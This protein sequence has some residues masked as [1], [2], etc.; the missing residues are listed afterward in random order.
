MASCHDTDL[1]KRIE[2][3]PAESLSESRGAFWERI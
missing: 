2:K 1:K 3:E